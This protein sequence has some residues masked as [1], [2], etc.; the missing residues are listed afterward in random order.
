MIT[1]FVKCFEVMRSLVKL[2]VSFK[3]NS[4]KHFSPHSISSPWKSLSG[5][6]VEKKNKKKKKTHCCQIF[7]FLQVVNKILTFVILQG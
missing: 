1:Q 2:S 5:D 3:I 7:F 4:T 6:V